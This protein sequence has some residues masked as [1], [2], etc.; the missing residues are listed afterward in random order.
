M[1]SQFIKYKLCS[2]DNN[3]NCFQ[4]YCLALACV[5]Q[6]FQLKQRAKFY[7]SI[8]NSVNVTESR[9]TPTD[10]T[11]D[12]IFLFY[13]QSEWVTISNNDNQ[14]HSPL[15][16]FLYIWERLEEGSSTEWNSFPQW[17]PHK[18]YATHSAVSWVP[19]DCI[20]PR[21]CQT[22][23]TGRIQS[24]HWAENLQPICR[25]SVGEKEDW[26]QA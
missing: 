23:W 13:A 9:A 3:T 21:R 4:V 15:Q 18:Q 26:S 20:F 22:R 5:K 8:Y 12:V 14:L 1:I 10:I 2:T 19:L 17:I 24:L 7:S 11:G 25:K 16:S 6:I